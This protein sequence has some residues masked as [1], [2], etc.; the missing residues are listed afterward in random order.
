MNYEQEQLGNKMAKIVTD[1]A[2][3]HPEYK[4]EQPNSSKA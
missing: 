4:I 3:S 2:A 1:W